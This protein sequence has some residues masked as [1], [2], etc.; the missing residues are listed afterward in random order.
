M[1]SLNSI[2]SQML[3]NNNVIQKK[4]LVESNYVTPG[5]MTSPGTPERRNELFT[6]S[7]LAIGK[8]I[9]PNLTA[10]NNSWLHESERQ[11]FTDWAHL[12]L[13]KRHILGK[14]ILAL[15]K[16]PYLRAALNKQA[17]KSPG[18]PGKPS[19]IS[20]TKYITICGKQPKWSVFAYLCHH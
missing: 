3:L 1:K 2:I 12:N 19:S 8:E 5:R 18:R 14:Y 15:W 16:V 6:A 11:R 4:L 9:P 13:I 10:K 20:I 17:T 7:S